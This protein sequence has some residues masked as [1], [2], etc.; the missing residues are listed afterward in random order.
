MK[1]LSAEE[2]QI[3]KAFA[4]MSF[5]K[6]YKYSKYDIYQKLDNYEADR[7]EIE[8]VLNSEYKKL[9]EKQIAKINK[10]YDDM[11][12][13]LKGLNQEEYIEYDRETEI[14]KIEYFLK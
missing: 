9:A 8:D 12:E 3:I 5:K 10:K 14:K 13:E 7:Y 6:G 11:T 1:K 2:K 4:K